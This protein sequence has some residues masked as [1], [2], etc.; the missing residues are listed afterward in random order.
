MARPSVPSWFYEQSSVIPFRSGKHGV[1]ILLIT[2]KG[3]KHW[4]FPKGVIEP[5][6]SPRA[7][8]RK[9]AL[10]EAGV[11]GVVHQE[12]V[13]EYHREKWNGTCRIQVYAMEVTRTQKHWEEERDR[14]RL[15]VPASEAANLIDRKAL[16]RML[17]RFLKNLDRFIS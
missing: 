16:R 3:K 11:E 15:W 14:K 8:A 1:E 6:L 7:S 17:K 10:E 4:I 2:S 12:A 9:E 13:G 5:G